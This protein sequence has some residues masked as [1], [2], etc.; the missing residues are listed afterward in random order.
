[1]DSAADHGRNT[2]DFLRYAPL[3]ATDGIAG[4]DAL[5]MPYVLALCR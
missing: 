2:L 3:C 4:A 1:M 5:Q